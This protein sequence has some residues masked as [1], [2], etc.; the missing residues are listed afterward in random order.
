VKILTELTIGR[1]SN[2]LAAFPL[3]QRLQNDYVVGQ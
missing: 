2:G 3:A 1:R